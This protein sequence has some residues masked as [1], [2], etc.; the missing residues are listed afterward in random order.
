MSAGEQPA[1]ASGSS[2][3]GK[4]PPDWVVL[5]LVCLGA[6]MVILDV[7]VVNVALPAIRASLGF[8]QTGLQWVV[9]AYTLTFAGFLLLGGRAADLYGRR[10]VFLIGLSIFTIASLVGG[11]AQNQAMLVTAR[12]VQG[13]GG[14]ILS[15]ATLTILITTFTEPRARSRALGIW[16]AVAAGGGAVGVLLGG[17]LTDLLSWRWIL[18]INIPVGV[19]LLV[20][21]V[22]LLPETRGMVRSKELDLW[23]ALTIT[24]SLVSLVYAVVNTDGGSWTGWQTLVGLPLAAVLFA[25]FIA[26][27]WRD[28]APL[29]PLRL[30]RSRSLTGANLV[31][32]LLSAALFAM[33]FFL[34]LYMQNVLGYSPLRAGVAFVPQTLS[35]MIGAQISSRAVHR[36]GARPLLIAGPLA[37]ALGLILLAQIG[38]TTP[39]FPGIALPSVLITLGLGLSFPPLTLAAT[40]GVRRE[41]SG[42]ASGLINTMRQIGGALGLAILATISTQ[43]TRDFLVGS[44]TLSRSLHPSAADTAQALTAGFTRGFAV[45]AAFALAAAVAALIVPPV[46]Q[47]PVEAAAVE[48]PA[49]SE[50]SMAVS[51][52]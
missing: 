4:H 49:T 19:A 10:R 35:I 37:T 48:T 40:A 17:V 31:M 24:G 52:E 1:G 5:T 14:A 2:S 11:L 21:A 13:F 18:F 3:P 50:R 45:A 30:F 22:M 43:R 39:Y 28:S 33:W 29:V 9:N 41:E 47:T 12:A 51:G 20:G 46:R 42:L 34:S 26:I 32:L 25:A 15:P 38:A 6:F 23:G 27:E 7:S 8:S 16:S 36:I 44:R